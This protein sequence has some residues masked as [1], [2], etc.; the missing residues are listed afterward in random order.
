[1]ANTHLIA[2]MAGFALASCMPA[3]N[4][5]APGRPEP[6]CGSQLTRTVE[7]RL[8]DLGQPVDVRALSCNGLTQ[9]YFLLTSREEQ[10]EDWLLR[11]QRMLQVFRSEGLVD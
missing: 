11:R 4:D 5:E 7:D 1:M 6:R 9:L 3:P 2:L 8:P 10:Q